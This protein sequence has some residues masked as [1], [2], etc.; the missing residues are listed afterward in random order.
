M[1]KTWSQLMEENSELIIEEMVN[2]KR[3]AESTLSGWRVGVEMDED[4]NVWTTGILSCGSQ[5][6][7]SFNGKTNIIDWVGV[8]ELDYNEMEI[9]HDPENI[10]ILEAFELAK[11]S[12]DNEDLYLLEW[13]EK[14]YPNKLQEWDTTIREYE[15][16]GFEED[17]RFKLLELISQQKSH[18]TE[19]KIIKTHGI[20]KLGWRT[21]QPIT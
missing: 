16:D 17:A 19:E 20:E 12:E 1:K 5:S 7:T 21:L 14:N 4:G 9:L 2:A 13:M 3:E 15:I 6:E 10:E 18:E 8:W 11:I